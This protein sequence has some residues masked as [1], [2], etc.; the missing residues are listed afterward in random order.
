MKKAFRF[1]VSWEMYG[2]IEIEAE[3]LEEAIAIAKAT[4][5]EIPLPTDGDYAD[6]SFVIDYDIDV[7]EWLNKDVL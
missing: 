4:E 3:T 6:D 2:E 7:L 1:G 5:D